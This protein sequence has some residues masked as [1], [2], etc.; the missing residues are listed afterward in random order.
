MAVFSVNTHHAYLNTDIVIRNSQETPIVVKDLLTSDEWLI[1][2]VKEV[3]LSH[4]THTLVSDD[5]V[6]TIIIE[7]AIKFGG[8]EIKGAFVFDNN[9]WTFI[10]M[11]DRLYTVN[12][13][14]GE[15][16]VEHMI[17]P[18]N[19]EAFNSYYG[20]TCE[21]FLFNT[22]NDFSIYNVELGKNLKTFS[23]HIYSNNHLIIYKENDKVIVYDYR[24]EEVIVEFDGQYS[25]GNDLYFVREEK[26]YL[27]NLLTSDIKQ[28]TWVGDLKSDYVLYGDCIFMLKW[29]EYKIYHLVYLN[30]IGNKKKTI[31][32]QFPY[33]VDSWLG[34]SLF[35]LKNLKEEFSFF[36]EKEL[37]F[38]DFSN[39]KHHIFYISILDIKFSND[40][41]NKQIVT[42]TGEVKHYPSIAYGNIPFTL[43]G[44]S[45]YTIFF[46]NMIFG[47]V[48]D[49]VDSEMHQSKDDI[50]QSEKGEKLLVSSTSGNLL[51]V[52][53]DSKIFYR[54]IKEKINRQLFDK[55]FDSSYYT[56]AYFTSDGKNVVFKNRGDEFSVLGFEKLSFDKF[57]IEG[58]TVPRL[59]GFNGYKLEIA[60]FDSRQPVWRDPISLARV[61]L[62][63]LSNYIF[64]SPDGEFSA[65]NDFRVIIRNQITN[66]DI[67]NEEYHSLVEE[68]DFGW[69][70]SDEDK[71]KKIIKRK[72]FVD[73]TKKEKLFQKITDRWTSIYSSSNLSENEKE[74][75][76]IASIEKEIDE[77]IY[78]KE[79]FT[80]LFLDKLGYVFYKN[81]NTLQET[82]LLIGR[83]V[84][85]LNYVSFSCDSRYLA[86]GAKMRSD[87]FRESKDGVFV[88]YDLKEEKE[89]IRQEK[90]LWA[91]WM[92]MFSKD[93]NIA[94]YDSKAETFIINKDSDYKNI[95]KIGNRSLLCF[96]PSGKYIALSD[97]NYIDY[98]HHSHKDWG[99]QPSGNIFIHAI[100]EPQVCISQYND[101]GDGISGVVY[102]GKSGRAG[103]VASVAFS[104][105]E[106]RLMAVGDDG[107]VVVR[108]LHFDDEEKEYN[109]CHTHDNESFE[110]KPL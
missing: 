54:N 55:L 80:S 17:S 87:E 14:T 96:S 33:Y 34:Y 25:I 61:K 104:S 9:P 56:N 46:S 57:D 21:F 69:K 88:L 77:F 79:N 101:F 49:I 13:N 22:K 78:K 53:Y 10:T 66:R 31:S 84:Y 52:L 106:K 62:E 43:S 70:D 74:E 72:N 93:G 42:L 15:E 44:D 16:K 7:D 32:F 40:S 103:N 98:T 19:I 97:Q 108:N 94:Y 2:D 107:V 48:D 12:I 100:E 67:T 58:A 95:Q 73:R 45:K 8:S 63:D 60:F 6:E 50:Y 85:Y 3:R 5:T 11:K 51:V 35:R 20:K 59:A 37:T 75:K 71:E 18:D 64:M 92:T 110:R 29:E 109:Y 26:L 83:S 27:L 82:R 99:H 24:T 86:F 91:V 90:G 23:N 41:E 39:I 89:I 1:T 76:C 81:N 102:S 28:I 105:D 68:Y 30:S 65:Q 38:K 47:N 4:G 36:Q